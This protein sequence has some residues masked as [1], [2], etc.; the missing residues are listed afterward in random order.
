MVIFVA[1]LAFVG[2]MGPAII[3]TNQGRLSPQG[4]FSDRLGCAVDKVANR[5]T[6]DRIAHLQASARRGDARAMRAIGFLLWD[7]VQIPQD[8]EAA[9]GWFYEA[10]IRNDAQSMQMLGR[11]F[12]RGEGV[13][14]DPK[15]A[16][17]WLGRAA[18]Q[19]DRGDSR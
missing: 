17:F 11:A 1:A 5:D 7:G 19:R 15:L 3:D 13:T 6:G 14:A 8:R 9:V 4:C 18:D 12:Q 10:A 16:A 2:Q